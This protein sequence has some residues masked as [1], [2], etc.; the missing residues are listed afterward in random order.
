[1]PLIAC[2]ACGRQISD[3]A[4][5][6]IQCGQPMG[7]NSGS[8]SRDREGTLPGG[9]TTAALRVVLRLILVGIGCIAL[10][11][12]GALIVGMVRGINPPSSDSHGP[13]PTA[14]FQVSDQ[15]SDENCT[16]LGDYCIRV[17]CSF[18]NSGKG[19]GEQRV[20]AQL[21]DGSTLVSEKYSSLTLLAGASQRVD[22]DFPEA[23]LDGQ[24]DYRYRCQASH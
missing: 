7:R 4:E 15:L 10:L 3:Q 22:F 24:H 12:I 2:A 19:P 23:E 6:C 8:F 9:R 21:L 17:H 16:Q 20:S 1:M 14:V 13:A 5:A 18:I 11:F